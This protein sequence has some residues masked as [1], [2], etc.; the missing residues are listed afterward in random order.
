VEKR[1]R[2]GRVAGKTSWI[3]HEDT[4]T[5][6]PEKVAKN[7]KVYSH[8]NNTVHKGICGRGERGGRTTLY[9]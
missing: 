3:R 5:V 4:R 2:E 6:T 8:S 7:H 1:Q 9:K